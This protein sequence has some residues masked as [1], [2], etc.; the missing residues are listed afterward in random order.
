MQCLNLQSQANICAR[1]KQAVYMNKNWQLHFKLG[2]HMTQNNTNY[3]KIIQYAYLTDKS[4]VAYTHKIYL[5]FF[6]VE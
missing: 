2:D 6:F 5:I 1:Q 3:P 4:T